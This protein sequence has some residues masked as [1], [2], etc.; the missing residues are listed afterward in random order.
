MGRRR[1]GLTKRNDRLTRMCSGRRAEPTTNH[2]FGVGG[3][4]VFSL[5]PSL[6]HVSFFYVKK[7]FSGRESREK[8]NSNFADMRRNINSLSLT[9]GEIKLTIGYD[10]GTKVETYQLS[11]VERVGVLDISAPTLPAGGAASANP[12]EVETHE[13]HV[14]FVSGKI[15][16]IDYR[17]VASPTYA[18]AQALADA[19]E[20]AT[21]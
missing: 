4:G 5:T 19:I 21:S 3:R 2:A 8:E 1:P 17:D 7:Y 10:G 12:D 13:A 20:A 18:S 9:G 15:L 6:R 14:Y 16:R 11:E